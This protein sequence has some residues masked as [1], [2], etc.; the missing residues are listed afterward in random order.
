M[1]DALFELIDNKW[2]KPS[3]TI[4]PST[5]SSDL[6]IHCLKN[7]MK[8]GVLLLLLLVGSHSLVPPTPTVRL[9]SSRGALL[10]LEDMVGPLVV[11]VGAAVSAAIVAKE[12]GHDFDRETPRL[13]LSMES[14]ANDV[15]VATPLETLREP[16]EIAAE[17][18][19]PDED[20]P[21]N[22]IT[23]V[24]YVADALIGVVEGYL[25]IDQEV[26]LV[27]DPLALDGGVETLYEEESQ[28][29]PV[30]L[31]KADEALQPTSESDQDVVSE[32]VST[33]LDVFV[34]EIEL[35]EED[36]SILISSESELF[37]DIVS[38]VP[39]VADSIIDVVDRQL[40][41]FED[42]EVASLSMD[43]LAFPEEMISE[44]EGVGREDSRT[45]VVAEAEAM[46]SEET[47]DEGD[48]EDLGGV[49][50]L[51]DDPA[52]DY[53]AQDREDLL[54][55]ESTSQTTESEKPRE[56]SNFSFFDLTSLM[57]GPNDETENGLDMTGVADQI[58]SAKAWAAG[59]LAKEST[60][61]PV[62]SSERVVS[63]E[64]V[65]QFMEKAAADVEVHTNDF[66]YSDI[67]ENESKE[68]A[69]AVLAV[70]S[71]DDSEV[72]GFEG[73][74]SVVEDAEHVIQK[75]IAVTG[76]GEE[77][78]LPLPEVQE[79]V[80]F[81]P[82]P[83]LTRPT[84]IVDPELDLL[85]RKIHAEA[86]EKTKERLGLTDSPPTEQVET[87]PTEFEEATKVEPAR[88]FK[89]RSKK[90]ATRVQSFLKKRYVPLLAAATIVVVARRVAMAI[91][92]HGM[93]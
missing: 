59:I 54:L 15:S 9:P 37:E 45:V 81:E 57:E 63:D 70:G 56:K 82:R 55:V 24:P 64:P 25:E 32:K 26:G 46:M 91:L 83:P 11:A 36:E 14:D 21:L 38:G 22:A 3:N 6:F 18:V 23:G 48:E 30:A 65:D 73:S 41:A 61:L 34:Q 53:F 74:S 89:G 19:L 33:E 7:K 68:L 31:D 92:G 85:Q 88:A 40:L 16:C 4:I 52:V 66:A 87:K 60:S 62:K 28:R 93:L 50:A 69:A 75:S 5:Q 84:F 13:F 76:L 49:S 44:E 77:D 47:V 2:N 29:E 12:I 79:K 80:A 10:G 78:K 20:I 51:A 90:L 67:V 39:Y 42:G 17:E 71:D 86:K 1:P 35:E 8:F 58:D 72:D 43:P 27:V